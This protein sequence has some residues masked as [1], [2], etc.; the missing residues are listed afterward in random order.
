MAGRSTQFEEFIAGEVSKYQGSMVPVKA[1]LFERIA[2]RKVSC[3]RLHPNPYDEFSYPEV[4]PNYEIISQYGHGIKEAKAHGSLPWD[5][6][7]LVEKIRPDG[8]MIINGHHRWAA[9]VRYGMARV[10]IRVV[11]LTQETDIKK[12]LE[13][14]LHD[15]RVTFDLDEVILAYDGDGIPKEDI[16]FISGKLIK[17]R[18]RRGVPALFHYLSR[19]GYDIWVYSAN[20][21]SIEYIKKLFRKY[22]VTV[23]GIVTGTS[24]PAK[25]KTAAVEELKKQIAAR[26]KATLHIDRQSI[27]LT[28][29]DS[30]EFKQYDLSGDD[31]AWSREIMNIIGKERDSH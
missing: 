1:S 5:E 22:H 23:N 12:M 29:G 21:Y 9:A 17:E 14:S 16:G 26:Y 7:I 28:Y 24:R 25:H 10:Q 15:R 6:P 8:Y 20:Y 11:N 27:L 30:A 4:G 19:N 31:E 3:K 2:V 18:L 13:K